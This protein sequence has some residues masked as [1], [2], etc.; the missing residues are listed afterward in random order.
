MLTPGQRH[1]AQA[2][3]GLKFFKNLQ[4]GGIELVCAWI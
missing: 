3:I 1:V 2:G 4:I